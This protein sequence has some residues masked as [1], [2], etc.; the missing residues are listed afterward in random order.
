MIIDKMDA[1]CWML[2][3]ACP[4]QAGMLD[5]GCS[6]LDDLD[7]RYWMIERRLHRSMN[8]DDHR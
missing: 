5:A 6:I 3:T 8:A 7:A 4:P 2:D 1:G